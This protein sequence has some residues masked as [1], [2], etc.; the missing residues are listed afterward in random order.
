ME[1][2]L[3][4][5][6]SCLHLQSQKKGFMKE[7][8]LQTATEMFLT[9]GFKS[10]TMDDIAEKMS[11]SKKTIYTHFS[12][13]TKLV[14]ETT[15]G[16]FDC[17]TLGIDSILSL[18]YDPIEELFQIKKF[19]LE[20]L[21]DEKSSPQYQLQKYYPKLH[22]TL[23]KQQYDVMKR[24]VSE[25]LERGVSDGLFRK[26]I[27]IQFI[28]RVYFKGMV[29][30]KDLDVFPIEIFN[31]KYLMERYLEYHIRGIATKKGLL[32]LEKLQ[33]QYN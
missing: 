16:M 4:F 20:N 10:V 15:T 6:V 22:A 29:G 21:K 8:I 3:V 30:I 28:T 23:T 24:C 27:D 32:T 5:K 14:E 26:E 17:I 31:M 7:K 2:L 12:N 11:I 13:K 1:T 33:N 25:N 19:V 18:N 9:Y